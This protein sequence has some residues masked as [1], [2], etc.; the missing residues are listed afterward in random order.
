MLLIQKWSAGTCCVAFC[1]LMPWLKVCY[2]QPFIFVKTSKGIAFIW[3]IAF[4]STNMDFLSE[5]LKIIDPQTGPLFLFSRTRLPLT[6]FNVSKALHYNIQ[7][8]S[9][10]G[11]WHTDTTSCLQL[12][13]FIHM[14]FLIMWMLQESVRRNEHSFRCLWVNTVFSWSTF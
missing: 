8:M 4:N 1:T 10:R 2:S 12:S 14:Q 9:C 3:V 11:Y 7:Q 13:L 5:W 6:P